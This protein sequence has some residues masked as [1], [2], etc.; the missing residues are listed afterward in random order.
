MIGQTIAQYQILEKL[1]EGGMGVVYRAQD[2]K[3]DRTVALKFLPRH[4][5][6]NAA[7]QARFLQEAKA[8]AQINHP[9]VC[10]IIDIQEFQ[11]E[12]FIVMECIDG[13][14]MR[15]KTGSA[16]LP[17]Q[18]AVAY[19]IQIAE[20]LAEAHSKG[21]VHRDI[22][23]ENIMVNARDQVKVMDFGLAKLKGSLKLTKTSS[24]VGTL[25]Y[26]APEQIQG[27]EV[28]ARSDI[29]SFGVV[30]FEM[31][32]GRMPFR[33]EHEASMMYSILNEEPDPAAKYRSDLPG[34]IQFIIT[35]ALE[36]D[37]ADRY[38]Q[39]NDLLIDLRRIQRSSAKVSRASMPAMQ[40]APRPAETPAP[41]RPKRMAMIAGVGAAVLLVA[42]AIAFFALRPGGADAPPADA[43]KMLAV[44]P[45]E[46]MG[47]PDQEYFAD[48]IT[49]EIT[50]RL[51]GLSGLGVIARTSTMQYKKTTKSVQEIGK[52]LG[53]DYVLQGTIRWGKDADGTVRVRISPALVRVSDGTQTWSQPYDAVF[54]DVFK[55]QSDISTQVAGAMGIT[56]LQPERRSLEAR[57]T[58]SAEAY[59]YY[60]RGNDYFRRSYLEQDF[61]IAIDLFEKAIAADPMF[62]L[63]YAHAAETHAA[64]YWF[65]YD[66]TAER[67]AMAKEACD[68]A[69]ALDPGSPDAHTSLA[70]YYYW[71][72]LDYDRALAEFA[73]AAK[74]RPNDG[75]VLLGIGSVARRQ[76]KMDLAAEYMEKSFL[77]D[78]RS[79]EIPYNLAQTYAIMRRYDDATRL[80][81]KCIALT[82][83]IVNRYVYKGHI[84]LLRGNNAK[85]AAAALHAASAISGYATDWSVI[86][87]EIRLRRMEGDYAGAI[88]LL[89]QTNDALV[90]GSD[91]NQF[92]TTPRQ[93]LLA[94][95]YELQKKP[96][97]ARAWYDSARALMTARVAKSPED[98]RYHSTLAIALA[99]LG[100]KEEALRA[101]NRGVELMPVSKESWRGSYRLKDLAEVEMMTGNTD[102]AIGHLETLLAIPT[103]FSRATFAYD[104]LW[105]PL[106]EIPRFKKLIAGPA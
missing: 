4:L 47:A 25:A 62:T 3:L 85:A 96:A 26:M 16:G 11:G 33:G 37:P 42:G 94:Q 77:V 10:S 35:R 34:D 6:A 29:F 98:S 40:A 21:I 32:T 71:G 12:Q 87:L 106:W 8:A 5:N 55:L 15:A 73:I 64:M 20:A 70:F 88:A 66:H 76:G 43:K 2:T 52:E 91:D 1:G 14:T 39:M 27:G 28:D 44:L 93:L 95:L 99:G 45:F 86:L 63:A 50:S 78:P 23:C 60:L 46:N 100:R 22:K 79:P 56:L 101:A 72:F 61:T 89:L 58:A 83:D 7:E 49:E 69:L 51:S 80:I 41:A 84:E 17:P 97:E 104:P 18:T 38:Q 68:K 57:P 90:R 36:K 65:F 74:A 31:L 81:D 105:A 59:D 54:S 75:R 102:A 82:P 53:I 103:E 48:G 92:A 24:T 19:A 67:L 13:V 30:L 9:N